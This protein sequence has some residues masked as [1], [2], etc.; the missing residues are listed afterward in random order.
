MSERPALRALAD[1]AGILPF[2]RDIAGRHVETTDGTREALLAAMGLD[3]TSERLAQTTLLTLQDAGRNGMLPP[4]SVTRR[5]AEHGPV[6]L[7]TTLR[8]PGRWEWSLH[9]VGDDDQAVQSEG[10]SEVTGD[11]PLMIST[12]PLSFGYYDVA[13][14]ARHPDEMRERRSTQRHIIA[15]DTC[16]SVTNLIGNHRT[17]GVHL[18]LYSLRSAANWGA[19]D[20]HDLGRVIDWMG[21]MGGAFVAMNP[22][23]ALRNRG[24]DISPYR[25]LSRIFGNPLYLHVPSV[26]GFEDSETVRR[27]CRDSHHQRLLLRTRRAERVDYQ[28]VREAQVAVLKALYDHFV[29]RHLRQDTATGQAYRAFVAANGAALHDFATYMAM[30]EHFAEPDFRHWPAVY[31]D[32]RSAATQRFRR[33]HPDDVDFH[34]WE[35]FELRRQLSEAEHRAKEAGLAIGLYTD[36]A[37]GSGPGGADH[38]SFPHLFVEDAELGAPP[39][40][41]STAGQNWAL[42]PLDPLRLER[43][44]YRYWTLLIRGAL[45]A[46]GAIRLDHVMGLSRQFWIPRGH[47]ASDGAYVR[48]PAEDLLGILALESRRYEAVVVGEDL[49]TVP[50]GLRE[51]LE[52]W[53]VL[54]TRVFYFE[55]EPGGTFKAAEEYPA[56]AVASATTHDHP[57]L[58]GFWTGRDLEL[59]RAT[60]AIAT[61]EAAET[62]RAERA[63]D[64]SAIIRRLQAAGVLVGEPESA[65]ALIAAIH[66]F[67]AATPCVLASASLDDLG[68]EIDPVNLPGV[69]PERFSSWSR[70]MRLPLETLL[71]APE[72]ITAIDALAAGRRS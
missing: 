1:R 44:G 64:R 45:E 41:Y 31:R 16:H 40:D 37:I 11:V 56:N 2:Y 70:P 7:E 48:F 24:H 6:S 65:A 27:L 49:G 4:T 63:R 39:D 30:S 21:R 43:D 23:H 51:E 58:A 35:Q 13:L 72:T 14:V 42:P 53:N 54:S 5:R 19:G 34:V 68:G 15:P 60:G 17:F 61:D 71:D 32:P 67:L 57:P 20:I 18:N 25:P 46:A 12:P 36:L 69:G 8:A 26:P 33:D 59:R 55:R 47:P 22:L 50:E 3:A 52:R 38:W 28:G 9:I 10:T 62:A 66:R 29:H